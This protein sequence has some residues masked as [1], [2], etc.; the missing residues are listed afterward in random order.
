M[1]KNRFALPAVPF[2]DA[3]IAQ[4]RWKLREEGVF[5]RD[6]GL[7]PKLAEGAAGGEQTSDLPPCSEC[8]ASTRNLPHK[9]LPRALGAASGD[10]V[11]FAT[12]DITS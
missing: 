1:L 10:T 4:H 7:S 3:A 9:G 2:A 6:L 11:D 12:S 8:L 5:L